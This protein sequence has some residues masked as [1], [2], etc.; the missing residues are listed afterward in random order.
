MGAELAA[1]LR[2]QPALEQGAED[3]G[4]DGV[5]V[6]PAGGVQDAGFFGIKRQRVDH[7]EEAAV[8]IRDVFQR[9]VAALLHGG[10]EFAQAAVELLAIG[11]ALVEQAF[12]EA[13]RQ[14]FGILGEEA[15]QALGEEMGDL[16]LALAAGVPGAQAAGEFGEGAGGFVGDLAVVAAG[17]EAFRRFEQPRE[18]LPVFRRA[19]VLDA[20]GVH[21]GRGAGEVG[22][23]LDQAAVGNNQQ[24][25]VVE[26][27]RVGHQLLEGFF[28]VGPG[29]LVFPREAV[30][31][32]DIGPA[33][34]AAGA[35]GATLEA[36]VFGVSWLGLAE[37]F[38]EVE[39]MRL[40]AG[41]LGQ[42][43][44]AAAGLPFGDEFGGG[45]ALCQSG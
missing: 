3:G 8:E 4:V 17:A 45:H 19:D 22:V 38:A 1:L 10:E 44:G 9:E 29:G 35:V 41:T 12:E 20:E 16:L 13:A 28:E 24:R 43:V 32:P 33:V 39:E 6:E 42:C 18:L 34:I 23:D 21:L 11:L 37:Q 2:V 26:R 14:E 31:L 5:P 27:Q 40:R 36:V 25:R 30:A 7:F 15:E